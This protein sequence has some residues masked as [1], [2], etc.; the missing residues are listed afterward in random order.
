LENI[1]I[2]P[3]FECKMIDFGFAIKIE[4]NKHYQY[5]GTPSYMSPEI[6]KR[7]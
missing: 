2:T 6:I 7:E 3:G 5:C 1:L 4:P